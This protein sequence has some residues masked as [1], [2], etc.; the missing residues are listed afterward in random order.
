M[1]NAST[2][3]TRQMVAERFPA[4]EVL[5]L[6]QNLGGAGGFHEGIRRGAAR[7]FEWLWLMDDD[8]IPAPTALEALLAAP[9][10]LGGLPEPVVLGSKVV[11]T[12]GR[13]HPMNWPGL[14]LGD[15][16]AVLDATERGLLPLRWNTFPSTL[17]RRDAIERHGLPHKHYWIWGD[18]IEYLARVLRDGAGYLV[19][20]S[21]AHHKTASAYP[22]WEGGDR[23]YYAMRNALYT[24]RGDAF[25]R[26]EKRQ[27]A[28]IVAGQ[29]V[30]YLRRERLRPHSLR[31]VAR[32]LRDGLTTP[33]S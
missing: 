19:P 3:G 22:A 32:G 23:F 28:F 1:D 17:I 8:T 12:D 9:E 20:E 2:D 10:R 13:M 30:R 29:A 7:G 26:E 33:A 21:V 27:Q 5:A 15:M 24:L 25:T 16:D 11:W 6:P 18:D 14:R 31:I 4:V